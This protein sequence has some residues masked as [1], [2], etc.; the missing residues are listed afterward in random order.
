M[1]GELYAERK[2]ELVQLLDQLATNEWDTD[3]PLECVKFIRSNKSIPRILV[4]Y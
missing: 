4:V 2:E 3:S 1:S